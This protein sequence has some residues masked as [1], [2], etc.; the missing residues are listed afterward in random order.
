[1]SPGHLVLHGHSGRC[2]FLHT[3][4]AISAHGAGLRNGILTGRQAWCLHLSTI[5]YYLDAL[6]APPKNQTKVEN[7]SKFPHI[8]TASTE[9]GSFEK[10]PRWGSVMRPSNPKDPE[11]LGRGPISHPA[12]TRGPVWSIQ[13]PHYVG[14]QKC[15]VFGKQWLSLWGSVDAQR[16]HERSANTTSHGQ[17]YMPSLSPRRIPQTHAHTT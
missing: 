8:R 9:N 13:S 7:Q 1:M 6:R 16:Q 14:L 3:R 4:A 2:E 10:K 11:E 12:T 5:R 15:A 17:A